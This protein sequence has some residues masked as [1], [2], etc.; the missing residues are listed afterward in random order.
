MIIFFH[1]CV[2]AD[3]IIIDQNY[4]GQLSRMN[5]YCGNNYPGPIVGAI[6]QE[7][8][9]VFNSRVNS[10]KE[11]FHA[12][13][14]FLNGRLRSKLHAIFVLQRKFKIFKRDGK[15]CIPKLL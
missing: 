8:K 4:K 1:R 7:M 11:G 5:T 10:R 12:R 9:I 15:L 3:N 6:G 2:S 14:E 13:F